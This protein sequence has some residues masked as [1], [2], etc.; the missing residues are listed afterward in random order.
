[1]PDQPRSLPAA[2]L[3]INPASWEAG[4][5]FR[6]TLLLHYTDPEANITLRRVGRLLFDLSLECAALWP[7]HPEE[8][9]APRCV[10]PATLPDEEACL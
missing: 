3:R 1:M 8:R 10:S 5:G 4:E 9:P 7:H 2:I 6:E